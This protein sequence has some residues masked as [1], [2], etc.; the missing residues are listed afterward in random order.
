MQLKV[1]HFFVY[2]VNNDKAGTSLS[3]SYGNG[4][5][6]LAFGAWNDFTYLYEKQFMNLCS[7]EC[8][9]QKYDSLV[10]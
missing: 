8:L 5:F 9:K 4:N 2:D 10:F 1:L 7:F 6:K 3:A